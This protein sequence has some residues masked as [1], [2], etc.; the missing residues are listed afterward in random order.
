MIWVGIAAEAAGVSINSVLQNP[1]T[2][3]N[4][5]NFVIA[6][7]EVT[8]SQ[9]PSPSVRSPYLIVSFHI[10]LH[11]LTAVS[12]ISMLNLPTLT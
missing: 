5:I 3:H 4:E 10:S 8:L 6:T 9:V 12:Q 11:H 2:N 7:E 1:I